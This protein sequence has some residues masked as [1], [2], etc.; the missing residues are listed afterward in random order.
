MKTYD[1]MPEYERQELVEYAQNINLGKT[2]ARWV[3][4]VI[5]G[6]IALIVLVWVL[7]SLA[8]PKFKAYRIGT[9]RKAQVSRAESDGKAKVIE[10]KAAAEADRERAAGTADANAKIAGSLT[11]EYIT[12]LYVDQLDRMPQ[13]TIIYVPT[14]GGLPILEAGRGVTAPTAAAG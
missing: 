14:E 2:I 4:G 1:E 11:P 12:W 3:I 8:G 6:L 7:T 5:L 13:G 9:E 10:A